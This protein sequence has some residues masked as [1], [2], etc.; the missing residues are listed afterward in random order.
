VHNSR[1][2]ID[3][4]VNPLESRMAAYLIVDTVLENPAVYEEYK[5]KAKPL[6]EQYGGEYLARGGD[7]TLREIDLWSPSRLVVIRFPDATTANR[8]LDS[9]AYQEILLISKKCARRTV[10][11]LDGL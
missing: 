8:C 11:V 1:I 6:I 4:P 5:L 2:G 9:P 7:M 3:V 10:V